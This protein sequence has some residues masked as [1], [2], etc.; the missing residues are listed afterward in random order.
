MLILFPISS[1]LSSPQVRETRHAQ[2]DHI[3]TYFSRGLH[4]FGAVFFSKDFLGFSSEIFEIFHKVI[5]EY[6]AIMQIYVYSWWVLVRGGCGH[7]YMTERWPRKLGRSA[8]WRRC[9][10]PRVFGRYTSERCGIW[11][12]RGHWSWLSFGRPRKGPSR[13]VPPGSIPDHTFPKSL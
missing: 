10:L 1:I 2:W 7:I 11:L 12:R 3:Q 6:I 4:V 8:V 5:C 13:Q 9:F